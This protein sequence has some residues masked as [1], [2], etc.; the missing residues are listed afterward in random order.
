LFYAAS[1]AGNL[2]V[3]APL[4]PGGVFIDSAGKRWMIPDILWATRVVSI[5]LLMPLSLIA[6]FKAARPVESSG[7]K[8]PLAISN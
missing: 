3:V 5:C 4:S 6:W 7:D 8:V 1:A 2:L